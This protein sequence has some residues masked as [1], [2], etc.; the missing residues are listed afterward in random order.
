MLILYKD[1]SHKN[2]KQVLPLWEF[3]GCITFTKV[4]KVENILMIFT[5]ITT[6]VL[7][8]DTPRLLDE[9]HHTIQ[10]QFGKGK[11]VLCIGCCCYWLFLY[12]WKYPS[13]FFRANGCPL[14]KVIIQQLFILSLVALWQCLVQVKI[15]H[16]LHFT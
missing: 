14:L 16:E 1:Q 6:I 11:F 4:E 2:H 3:A 5:E 9:W 10:A 12:C 13:K 7:A 15:T 8:F